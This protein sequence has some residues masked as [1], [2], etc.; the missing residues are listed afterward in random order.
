[1]PPETG[2]VQASAQS[3]T[4]RRIFL[5]STVCWNLGAVAVGIFVGVSFC[6]FSVSMGTGWVSL[7]FACAIGLQGF[8]A[9]VKL[10]HTFLRRFIRFGLTSA[11]FSRV[12]PKLMIAWVSTG[13]ASLCL[14]VA[15]MTELVLATKSSDV[16]QVKVARTGVVLYAVV[17]GLALSLVLGLVIVSRI[18]PY[19]SGL[20]VRTPTEAD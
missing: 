5:A 14:F 4:V 7:G 3:M 19:I 12:S 2:L 1:M 18:T 6:S 10:K 13:L 11:A 15:E 16:Q 17:G 9:F 8:V 20:F